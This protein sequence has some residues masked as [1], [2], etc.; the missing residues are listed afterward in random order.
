MSFPRSETFNF[1]HGRNPTMTETKAENI[2]SAIEQA[3]GGQ[4][5]FSLPRRCPIKILA[6]G[7]KLCGTTYADPALMARHL[8]RQHGFNPA[9]IAQISRTAKADKGQEAAAAR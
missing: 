5:G 8:T 1:I 6:D 2:E 9:Q 3:L 4:R 7:E